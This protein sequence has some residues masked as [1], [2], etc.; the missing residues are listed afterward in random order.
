MHKLD[1]KFDSI[2]NQVAQLGV[3]FSCS[4]PTTRKK[5]QKKNMSSWLLSSK[6]SELQ[7]AST[8]YAEFGA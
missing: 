8:A 2:M 7:N 3:L 5:Q 6:N 4:L 1:G